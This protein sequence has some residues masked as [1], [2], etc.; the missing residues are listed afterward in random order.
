M[1]A[2][3]NLIPGFPL[4]GGRVLRAAIWWHTGDQARANRAATV[5]GQLAAFGLIAYGAYLAL[6]GA[7]F[8][9]LWLVFI[10]PFLR[11]AAAALGAQTAIEGS[12][13]GLTVRQIMRRE[14]PRVSG[15]V[16]LDR[17]VREA[18]IGGG[19]RFSLVA[20]GERQ[21]PRGLLSIT[22]VRARP[23]AAW[24]EVT[25]GEIMVPWERV[26]RIGPDGDLLAAL[27]LMERAGVAQMPVTLATDGGE[28]LLGVLAR[29][30][31]R[32]YLLARQE[33]RASA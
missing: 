7:L 10:G 27:Q 14:V 6:G 16:P 18:I 4:D 33:L 31:V 5:T 30:D 23:E 3:F 11:G 19:Q 28:E 26:V 2:L 17:F 13:H 22:N 21:A 12:R 24:G 8:S 9:G 20:E 32:R 25:V 1:L 15:V 29:D